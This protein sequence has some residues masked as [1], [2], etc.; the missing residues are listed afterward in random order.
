MWYPALD[1]LSLYDLTATFPPGYTA[2]SEAEEITSI[3]KEGKIE[4]HFRFPFVT[5]GINLVA[6]DKYVVTRDKFRDIDIYAYFFPEKPGL[7]KT[8][9][10]YTKKY[11]ALYEDL[12]GAYPYRRFS[13]VENFLP[14]GYSMPSFTLL[15]SSVVRLPFIVN[16]SL[17]H[18][19][20][21]Q[22]FGNLVY[23]D[24]DGGNWA[25]GL[26]T[27]LAD[28]LY[29]EQAGEGRA[30]RKQILID[31]KSYVD[32]DRDVPVKHFTGRVDRSS[33]AIGYGK[34]AMIFHMLK[35]RVGEQVF[36]AS[37]RELIESSRF[38]R[39]SWSDIRAAF[40]KH[41][42]EGLE[43]FFSQW[44]EKEGLM[45]L[46]LQ[47]VE[48]SRTGTKF[49]LHLN[50]RQEGD[51]FRA[52]L[53]VTIYSRDKVMFY[54]LDI[55]ERENSFELKLRDKPYKIVLDEDYDVARGLSRNEFP[56]VIARILGNNS[57][58]VA[59]PEEEKE[60]YGE[61]I[62]EYELR[63]AV[64]KAVDDI[65][66]SDIKE[67]SI[68]ILGNDSPL[69]RM[70]Y[71][72]LEKEDAGSYILMKDNP[73][74]PDGV[75]AVFHGE[76]KAE[77][78]SAFR[79]ISHYGKYSKLLFN[80]GVNT[81]KEIQMT[82]RGIVMN[83]D[84]EAA[85]IEVS[86]IKTLTDVIRGVSDRKIIYAGEM[87]DVFAHHAVQ[88][89]IITGIYKKDRRIAIGM[90]M[91]Q[92]P[93]QHT[94]DS[95]INGDT[96][97]EEFLRESEYFE[98]WGFDYNLYKPILDFA[99]TEK[100]PVIAL[101][102]QREIIKQVTHNGIDSLSDEDRKKIPGEL[103]FS[104]NEYRERLQ[105][106]F[107]EHKNSDK[108]N[109]DYF[110]QSQILWDETM[111]ESIDSFMKKNP[112]RIMIVL[113]GQGHL[114]YGSGIPKRTFRRNGLDYAIVLIDEKVEKGI[115]DYVVFPKPVEG[116]TSP[117]LMV[118]LNMA[119]DKITIAGFPEKSV[120]EEA[121]IEAGDIIVSLDD[122]EVKT[123]HD[124][125]IFLMGKKKGD[126]IKVKVL[127]KEE[128]TDTVKEM[129]F[130]VKL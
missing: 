106:V 124:I 37:L 108:M 33:R 15:G 62:N 68:V 17:G 5:D 25:E 34:A 94:L 11:L 122:A 84:H 42:G 86:S 90:E 99:R 82:D 110:Y 113:A 92:K 71:G 81:G 79:K 75:A 51:T 70:L 46:T 16:T 105:E 56:P 53:P 38:K 66:V 36:Y 20:L 49:N 6:S 7:A 97:E 114:M 107:G 54:T 61:V 123:I 27:Y 45:Q 112:D 101:N 50:V 35:N 19:I 64:I 39:A 13:V 130:D 48:V 18:E 10:A 9:I 95:Y 126:L 2:I 43:W 85:A 111:S 29:K 89:D 59:L 63:G 129:D 40:E 118:F 104:D 96:T 52:R 3:M 69:I 83:L 76:S 100:V 24:Y 73:W 121:G 98:R 87:H 1:E 80:K 57:I 120:S 77:I 109:F 128:D 117:K 44:T 55:K 125:K 78:N 91:F 60:K 119:D 14:T 26:T 30:Y 22:W 74:N 32:T 23:I 67:N 47:E 28:H 88:L 72:S 127:R 93:F 41:A 4:Y 58:I 65:K 102:L 8:Y 116:V 21:H 12:L 103:D 115:A 31:Y